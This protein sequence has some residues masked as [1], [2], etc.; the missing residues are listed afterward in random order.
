MCVVCISVSSHSE[1][2]L[3]REIILTEELM[4]QLSN[5]IT[6]M[7]IYNYAL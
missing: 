1:G 2:N 5:S 7:T 4:I 3:I 6:F